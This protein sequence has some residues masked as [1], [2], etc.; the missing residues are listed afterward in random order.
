VQTRILSSVVI[1]ALVDP[2]SDC[3]RYIGQAKNAENRL[4][5]HLN[6]PARTRKNNWIRQLLKLGLKP[7]MEILEET[8]DPDR[9]ECFWIASL[10][11]AGANILNQ[12]DGGAVVYTDEIRA[13]LAAAGRKGKG[14]K[15][16]EEH[17]AK[18]RAANLATWSDP[19]KRQ[20]HSKINKGRK[21]TMKS[22]KHFR[23]GQ[24][25]R[26]GWS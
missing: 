19:V 9:D 17:K 5:G 21:H 13:K 4:L 7:I 11:A 12:N 14:R 22:K 25:R 24:L 15:K 16:S 8:S 3:I 18:L 20:E 2:R 6:D 26:Y 1:Y 10:R 23:D